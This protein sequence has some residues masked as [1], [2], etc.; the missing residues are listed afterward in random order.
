MSDKWLAS[1]KKPGLSASDDL[2]G[3]RL[4]VGQSGKRSWVRFYRHPISRKLIKMT[5]P[6]MGLAEARKMISDAQFDIAKGIDPIEKRRAEKQA[7]LDATEGTLNAVAKR[8]LDIKAS[9]LRSASYYANTLNRHILPTL[10]EKLVTEL[11]RGEIVAVLDRVERKSGARSADMALAV[12][13]ALLHWH[14]VRADGFVSPIVRGMRRVKP[15]ERMRT[16]SLTDDEIKS[17]WQAA[18]DP[19]ISIFGAV[20]RVLLLTG[21]RRNEAA[22]LR[23]SEIEVVRDNGDEYTV[24]RL[25]ARRSKNKQEIVRPLAKAVLDIIESQPV[26]N[27]SDLVFTFN[28]LKPLAMGNGTWKRYLDDVVRLPD[29]TLHDLRRTNRTLLSRCRV[30]FEIAE[31][32]LV[33]SPSLLV[34]TYDQHSHLPAMQEAVEKVAAEI[35]YIVEG[36]PKGKLRLVSS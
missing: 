10:G 21:A 34:K 20:V 15:A 4:Y 28:G 26:I 8:Y 32:V 24:W 9:K 6:F 17:V 12:L 31:R 23:R 13:S 27:G 29:W 30:P 3:L 36:K 11:R 1:Y 5:L 35:T 18:G 25:P 19:R 2:S 7:K 14:E 16:R 33:H 22:G